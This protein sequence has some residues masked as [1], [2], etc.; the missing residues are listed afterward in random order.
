V[1]HSVYIHTHGCHTTM[2]FK[3]EIVSSNG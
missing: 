3:A 2:H 1:K